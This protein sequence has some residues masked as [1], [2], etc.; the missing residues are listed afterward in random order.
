MQ[1]RNIHQALHRLLSARTCHGERP[2]QVRLV[3]LI[4]TESAP[5]AECPPPLR[6][7]YCRQLCLLVLIIQR[8]ATRADNIIM[9]QS[10]ESIYSP[11]I[12]GIAA[13]QALVVRQQ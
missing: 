13:E 11:D 12:A 8:S 6:C 10:T 7:R 1:E 9:A 3:F 2:T 4:I 5:S